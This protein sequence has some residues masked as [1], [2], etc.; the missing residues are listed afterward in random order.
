MELI[1]TLLFLLRPA[2][3]MEDLMMTQLCLSSLEKSSH[4]TV[5]V[6]NQG[7]WDNDT[8]TAYLQQYALN[9]IVIGSGSNAGTVLGH[10]QCFETIYAHYPE[11]AFISEIHPDMVFAPEWEDA[12]LAYLKTHDE[13][14]VSAGIVT[15]PALLMLPEGDLS[16]RLLEQRSDR[17]ENGFNLPCIHKAEVLKATDGYDARFLKGMQAFEDD[18][19]LLGYYYYYGTRQNWRP[20]INYNSI[21]YHAVGGQRFT[22]ND[23]MFINYRGLVKQYG[24]KG[25][26][27]LSN[28]LV[29]PI[30][31]IFFAD[32]FRSNVF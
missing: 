31:T 6:Y 17:I 3:L 21:V 13:P 15:D 1:H 11:A 25:L 19:L 7:C 30:Q 8:L 26:E 9:C 12:L 10:Q 16:A 32:M 18:S 29:N 27:V 20:K 24:F 23:D 14:V 2:Q 4:K 22:L 28:I 5:V